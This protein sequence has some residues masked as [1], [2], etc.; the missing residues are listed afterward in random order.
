MAEYRQEG[1]TVI[2]EVVVVLSHEKRWISLVVAGDRRSNAFNA[3]RVY[4]IQGHMLNCGCLSICGVQKSLR[5]L[6]EL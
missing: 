3:S 4:Q 2:S 6:Y 5:L 1:T